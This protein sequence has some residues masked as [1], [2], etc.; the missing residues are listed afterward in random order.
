MAVAKVKHVYV[1]PK[2]PTTG[3]MIEEPVYVHKNV[4]AMLYHPEWPGWPT[5]G[6]V[7]DTE[8]EMAEALADGWMKSP[9]DAGVDC[10]VARADRG[11]TGGGHQGEGGGQ[12]RARAEGVGA[13]P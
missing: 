9:A 4:P 13:C 5:A 3:E 2:D 8:Q 6:K 7:F 11:A 12:G 1:G 10:A